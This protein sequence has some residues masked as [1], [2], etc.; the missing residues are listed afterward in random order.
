MT[1]ILES[2]VDSSSIGSISATVVPAIGS[3]VVCEG[4]NYQVLK[5]LRPGLVDETGIVYKIRVRAA[6]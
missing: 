4:A 5:V 6:A 1:L 2:I 3:I